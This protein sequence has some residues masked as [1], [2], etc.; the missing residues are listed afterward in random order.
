MALTKTRLLKHDFPVHGIA[1]FSD[2][3]LLFR[4]QVLNALRAALQAGPGMGH[5]HIIS[6]LICLNTPARHRLFQGWFAGRSAVGT[7][8]QIEDTV[9]VATGRRPTTRGLDRRGRVDL[10]DFKPAIAF[11]PDPGE[12]LNP[13]RANPWVA[14]RA[15]WRSTQ[16]DVAGVSSPL[17]MPTDS[18]HPPCRSNTLIRVMIR[19]QY[20]PLRK[21]CLSKFK[22]LESQRR[23]HCG[24]NY[25]ILN[26]PEYFCCSGCCSVF[27]N[28][29][30]KNLKGTTSP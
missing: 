19:P 15:A 4:N 7:R 26:S 30:L 3:Y 29:F 9:E 11:S 10:S 8:P 27:L 17:E 20:R 25:Y 2:S 24:R 13:P 28:I 23:Y 1:L 18:C 14:E 22:T 21:R 16:S 12:C 6:L 5:M